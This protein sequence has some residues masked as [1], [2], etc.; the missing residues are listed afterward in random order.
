MRA[1]DLPILFVR[2]R[3]NTGPADAR[4]IGLECARAAYVFVLDA[5]N[6]VYPSCFRALHSTI[7]AGG[8]TGVY[9]LIRRFDDE[10]TESLGLLSM[11]DWNV[12]QLVR[13]PYI[14]AMA[15]LDRCRVLAIGGYATELIEHGWFGWEDYDLWLRLAQEGHACKLVPRVLSSY[16]VHGSSM[17]QR[18]NRSSEAVARYFH[19]KFRRLVSEHPGLDSY[20]GFPADTTTSARGETAGIVGNDVDRLARQCIELERR[21]AELY[22]SS[23]WR[24][25]APLRF[26][27]RCFTG[28]P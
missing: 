12:R 18:T 26:V 10:T 2:K 3:A 21:L 14:D 1:V 23:S 24:I 8:Y 6:S 25:T 11:Y 9:G 7:V 17:L 22:A 15:M 19:R 16:R 20:F 4:N 5:D 28:R 27:Y 13:R